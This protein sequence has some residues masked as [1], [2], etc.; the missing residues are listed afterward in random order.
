ME[1]MEKEGASVADR[2]RSI[3][4]GEI[5]SGGIRVVTQG[6]GERLRRLRRVLHAALQ[7]KA[8]ETYE[9]V[10]Y[11]HAKNVV[12]DIL[13]DPEHHQMHARR[14]A[15]SVIM[16]ITYGKITSTSYSDPE[17]IAVNRC[18][19]QFGHA[20]RP[21]AYLV[22]TYPVL[23]YIP[24]YLSKLKRWHKEELALFEGQLDAVRKQ[25]AEGKARPCFAK[26]LIERQLDYQIENKEI[27][28]VAGA[29]FGAGSD[30]TAAAISIAI[31]AAALH[32]EAQ[33]RVQ[34]ELDTI[35]GRDRLPTFAD[36]EML[37]HV[38]AFTLESFR[39]RPVSIGGVAHRTTKDIVW[40]GYVIP[41]GATVI[42]NH[43]A[44]ANDPDVFPNPERFDPQRW[45][46]PEGNV[47]DD[48]RFCTYGFGRRT[49]PGLHIANRSI[50]MNTALILWAFC[51]SDDPKAPIDTFDFT[52]TVNQH[53]AP[54]RV[55]FEPRSSEADIRRL[56]S[57]SVS[58]A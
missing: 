21:G 51:I 9:P 17:V 56:C 10:Q 7:P 39:W 54:F 47:R 24:G 40:G 49:C 36:Q 2:P 22:D 1:I 8:S 26:L 38:T 28:Y 14:Y 16:N 41:E 32:P 20:I 58:E 6:V 5:L 4:A 30:S 55:V 45:L 12:L 33:A 46:T 37:P 11:H 44:I 48:I 34:E 42:G 43:W 35:V 3:A 19:A 15:A 13:A 25:M 31:M 53:P 27:A 29:M 57:E 52:E 23:Q 18:L 50:F